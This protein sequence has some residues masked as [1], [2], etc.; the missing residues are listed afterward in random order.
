MKKRISLY[1]LIAMVALLAGMQ[2]IQ[3]TFGHVATPAAGSGVSRVVLVGANPPDYVNETLELIRVEVA[4]GAALPAHSHPGVQIA[5]IV[6]GELTYSVVVGEVHIE[7]TG[8]NGTPVS[9]EIMKAGATTVLHAGDAVVETEGMIHHA[10]NL[11]TETVV[12]YAS[13]LRETTEPASILAEA[14]PTS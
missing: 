12:I 5:S 6:A 14:T 3:S 11:G 1:G 9:V 10:E 13:A 4:P 7:R 2:T 8:V